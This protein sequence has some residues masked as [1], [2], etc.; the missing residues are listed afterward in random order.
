VWLSIYMMFIWL[1]ILYCRLMTWVRESHVGFFISILTILAFLNTWERELISYSV[2]PLTLWVQIPLRRGVLNTILCG[3]IC[4][5]L[6]AGRWFSRGTLVPSTMI[7]D[8]T[9]TSWVGSC[10]GLYFQPNN[11]WIRLNHHVSKPTTHKK[12]LSDW[13]IY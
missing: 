5:W 8:D 3:K 4:Q 7:Q 1:L 11:H 9:L 12:L 2:S 13:L 10:L 6:A